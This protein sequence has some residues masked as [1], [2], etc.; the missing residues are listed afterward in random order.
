MSIIII[1]YHLLGSLVVLNIRR[2]KEITWQKV[3]SFLEGMNFVHFLA[4]L[5]REKLA[6]E[7]DIDQL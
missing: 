7:F 2:Q 5:F 6:N 3:P 4:V 1:S